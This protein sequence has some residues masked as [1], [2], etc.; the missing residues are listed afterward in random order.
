MASVALSSTITQVIMRPGASD[1]SS[2]TSGR[3]EQLP[4]HIEG[5][6]QMDE[7][8]LRIYYTEYPTGQFKASSDLQAAQNKAKVVYRESESADGTPFVIIKDKFRDEK[9]H[10][11]YP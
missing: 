2:T 4:N 3:T 5:S 11:D 6:D 1:T 9:V 10:L 7:L 8:T